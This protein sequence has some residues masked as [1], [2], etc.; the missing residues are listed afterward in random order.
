MRTLGRNEL[1]QNN[2]IRKDDKI[3]H[4]CKSNKGNTESPR[5]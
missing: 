3:F 5:P 2:L 4:V 1:T